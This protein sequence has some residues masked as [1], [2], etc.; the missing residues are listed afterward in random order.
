MRFV[1]VRVGDNATGYLDAV[2]SVDGRRPERLHVRGVDGD[3]FAVALAG[4][5][6]V[7]VDCGAEPMT[8]EQ[9]RLEPRG[10][11]WRRTAWTYVLRAHSFVLRSV[12]QR[13]VSGTAAAHRRCA[14]DRSRGT[15]ARALAREP[16]AATAPVS[17]PPRVASGMHWYRW[18][19]ASRSL[20]S[21]AAA[22]GPSVVIGVTSMDALAPLAGRFGFHVLARF[23][24]LHAAEVTATRAL[25]AEAPRE[26][27]IRYLS[28]VGDA[29]RLSALPNDPLLSTIDRWTQLPYEWEFEATHLDDALE[30]SAGSAHIVVG[31]IDSGAADVPDLAGKVDQR[32][33]VSRTGK[34]TRDRG[35]SDLVGHGTAVASL[36]AANVDDGFGMAGFGGAAHLIAVR[37]WA[38]TDVATAAAL[39]KLDGLGVRIV[40]MSFGGDAP[41]T[42]IMLD[43]IHRAAADGILLIAAAGNAA[44]DVAH[45]AADLQPAGGTQSYGLAVG[46]SDVHGN[47]AFFSNSG[48]HLS[49]LAPGG[50]DGDCSGVLVATTPGA[51]ALSGSCYP[52]W[53][54]KGGALYA[55]VSG[56]SFA[57]PEV[58]GAAALVWAAR[59]NLRNYQ[60]ADIL[61]QTA[62]RVGGWSPTSG[63]GVLD[64]GAAVELALSCWC[65]ESS[66]RGGSSSVATRVTTR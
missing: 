45:P 31:T 24:L 56:T 47:L 50:Y 60:V 30:L 27:R 23:P 51:T 43:A 22:V 44:H 48:Y 62:R 59:P 32:W 40:N 13:T 28:P 16:A 20:Q 15:R 63:Y 42:P 14:L 41:E 11:R 39:I 8:I 3:A 5:A 57:A 9:V 21:R 49:L 53:D 55:Y 10:A 4:R 52:T 2:Y 25:V 58:A 33:T 61:K 37:E 65:I 18:R 1:L 36:I 6:Y 19:R 66:V 64:A 46:A 38:F 54:G 26:R 34:L 29:R 17:R 7:D 12:T 35:T